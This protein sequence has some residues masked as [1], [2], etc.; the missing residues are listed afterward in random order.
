[1]RSSS[2]SSYREKNKRRFSITLSD[3]K[4]TTTTPGNKF[5]ETDCNNNNNNK[6]NPKKKICLKGVE[7]MRCMSMEK[8][9]EKKSTIISR[10]AT[11]GKAAAAS[12][13]F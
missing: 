2:S 11:L 5:Q 1:L 10:D 3:V 4:P 13:S 8:S 9:R 6:N 7:E 12:S